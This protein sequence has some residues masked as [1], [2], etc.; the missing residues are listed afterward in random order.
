MVKMVHFMLCTFYRNKENVMEG[1]CYLNS[2]TERTQND[3]N[4]TRQQN[5]VE[6]GRSSRQELGTKG[7]RRARVQ[8][9]G[10]LRCCDATECRWW[11]PSSEIN[12]RL[13]DTQEVGREVGSF[14]KFSASE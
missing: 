6:Q 13:S 7:W 11:K 8:F 10:E 3:Q 5:P 9:T 14:L 2:K 1:K 4:G 12:G